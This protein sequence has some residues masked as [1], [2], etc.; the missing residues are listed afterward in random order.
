MTGADL[1]RSSLVGASLFQAGLR[2]ADLSHAD[3]ENANMS[4]ADLGGA[5]LQGAR[6]K[7]VLMTGTRFPGADLAEALNLSQKQLDQACG[8]RNTRL[9]DELSIGMC[10]SA[11]EAGEN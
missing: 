7:G 8:D 4:H 2:S 1:E 10:Q 11:G 3:L 6:M 9:P 5:N